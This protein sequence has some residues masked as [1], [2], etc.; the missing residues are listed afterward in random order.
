MLKTTHTALSLS[1]TWYGAVKGKDICK[2]QLENGAVSITVTNL[3]CAILS[4]YTPDRQGRQKNIVAGLDDLSQYQHNDYYLGCVVGR[5]ANRIAGGRF[6]LEG[7]EVLLS[8]N[9]APNHLHGGVVGFNKQVWDMMALVE[10]ENKVGVVFEYRSPDGE[11]GYPGNLKVQV[12]YTL[13]QHNRLGIHYSAVSDQCTPVNL[14]NHSYFNLTGFETPVIL[15]HLLQINAGYYTDKNEHNIPTGTILP[16]AG[17]P[18]DFSTPKKIGKDISLL[19]SDQGYDHNLIINR[20]K[21]GELVPAAL[22]SDPQT[23]RLLRVFTDQ[24]AIQVYTANFWDGSLLGRQQQPYIKHGAIALETQAFPDSPNHPG[25]PNTILHP[26]DT[27][28]SVTVY[29]FDVM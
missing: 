7:K 4:L 6:I 11:E 16:V 15:D 21:E 12:K 2:V 14:T 18:L 5:Y 1:P 8:V 25:F 17:T 13:D 24:P 26:G 27:Y 29:Q 9:N 3:G 23:G 20:A 22:L 19:L 28:R 10:E